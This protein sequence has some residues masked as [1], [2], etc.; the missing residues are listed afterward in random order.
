MLAPLTTDLATRLLDAAEG[1]FR[2]QGLRATTMD[3]LA[4]DLA[5]SKK[6]IYQHFASK[7]ELA[8]AVIRRLSD[9]IEANWQRL[10]DE[11]GDPLTIMREG[12]AGILQVVAPT[13][14][15]FF[16]DMQRAMPHMWAEIQARRRRQLER[17]EGLIA[18]GIQQG[19]F[20]ADVDPFIASRMFYASV[21]ALANP[22]DEAANNRTLEV[23]L[24]NILTIFVE[25]IRVQLE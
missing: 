12:I 24:R 25:G 16:K 14:S 3:E 10:Y 17:F 15:T 8:E 4:E 21:N 13:E 9:R 22:E 19:Q 7:E 23:T 1:R 2:A 20:R 18:E 6:T 11:G 5:I